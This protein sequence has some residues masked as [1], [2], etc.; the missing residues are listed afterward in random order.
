MATYSV[1]GL[2]DFILSLQQIAEIPDEVQSEILNAQA[3]IVASEIRSKGEAYG[4]HRTGQT[5]AHIRKGKVKRDRNWNRYI[6][7]TFNGK[8]AKGTRY[9]EIAFVN[10]YGKKN[11]RA[12]PFVTDA[13]QSS[14]GKAGEKAADVYNDWIKSKNL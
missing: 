14:E 8:N 10:N 3:D 6:L 12:R 2:S 9:A 13:R 5:L 4:I 1:D 11:Q 7:I